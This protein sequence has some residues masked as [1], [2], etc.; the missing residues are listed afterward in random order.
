MAVD[1][2]INY[3]RSKGY[4]DEWIKV[5]LSGILNR[6]KLTDVWKDNGI[7]ED[8]EYALLT[9]K[10]YET[11]SNMSASEYKKYK[12]LRKESLRDNMEDIEVV[13]ADLGEITTRNIAMNERP[14]GLEKNM[15]VAKRGGT[16]ARIARDYYEK[17]TG[18]KAVSNRNA[19]GNR[20]KRLK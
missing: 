2:A 8:Y 17:E 18:N 14:K 19:I 1:R 11:W 5:R 15:K 12:G 10:I 7:N 20:Y 13:L 4:S 3:Y 6:K 9:N 16:V